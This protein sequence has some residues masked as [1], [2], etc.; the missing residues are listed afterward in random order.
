MSPPY[1]VISLQ[2]LPGMNSK[3]E[4]FFFVLSGGGEDFSLCFLVCFVNFSPNVWLLQTK[5]PNFEYESNIWFVLNAVMSSK[6]K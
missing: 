6:C 4:L 5:S 2:V 3:W 1:H